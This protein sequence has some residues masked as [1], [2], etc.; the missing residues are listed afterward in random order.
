MN[1]PNH[2]Q[3]EN[4]VNYDL[5]CVDEIYFTQNITLFLIINLKTKAI[6]SYILKKYR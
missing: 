3:N 2:L 4:V 6:I 1:I 5:W